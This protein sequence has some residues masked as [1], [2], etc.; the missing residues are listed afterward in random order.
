[1]TSIV[2]EEARK[3]I[4]KRKN[5]Y[6]RFLVATLL[7]IA[8]TFLLLLLSKTARAQVT[9]K[10]ADSEDG[11]N[12][13]K[14]LKEE[15]IETETDE[16]NP[17]VVIRS[18][19]VDSVGQLLAS[20]AR[21]Q[22]IAAANTSA[23]A[24]RTEAARTEAIRNHE[25]L[26]LA[27]AAINQTGDA[28]RKA[29]WLARVQ[30]EE[31]EP[32][33]DNNLIARSA[34]STEEEEDR[35]ERIAINHRATISPTDKEKPWLA[36][37]WEE[38]EEEEAADN[39]V[40]RSAA[41]TE[42]EEDR[43]ERIAINHRA[44]ISP[45]DKEKPWLAR[46]WEEEAEENDDRIAI[47]P[48]AANQTE[49]ETPWLARAEAEETESSVAADLLARSRD[50]ETIEE[51]DERRLVTALPQNA[52]NRRDAPKRSA[53]WVSIFHEALIPP[54]DQ[55]FTELAADPNVNLIVDPTADPNAVAVR[56]SIGGNTIY[57]VSDLPQTSITPTFLA[58]ETE[59]PAISA[60]ADDVEFLSPEANAFLNNPATSVVL[61]FP[62][63]AKIALLI[64]GRVVGSD[65]VGRTETDTQT[66]SRIQTWYGVTLAAGDNQ[67]EV[68]STDSGEVLKRL[69]V[70]VR[71]MPA[72]LVLLS[73]RAIPADGRSVSALR[74][75]L[76][77]ETGNISRWEST[78][79]LEA[80]DGQFLGADAN[81][82][83]P[84]FQ[85]VAEQ[86]EFIAELQSSLDSGLVQLRARSGEF[87]TFGQIQFVTPQRSNLISGVVDLRFGAQ[88]TDYY[89]SYREFLPIDGDD[90]YGIDLDAAVFATGNIGQ[91]LY[92]GAYNSDRTLN[93]D[94]NGDTRLFRANNR[95]G[96]NCESTYATYG[97]DS[98][99]DIVAPSLDSVFLRLERT[100]PSAEAATDYVM[101]GDYNTQEFSAASQL[102]TAT[103]RQLHGF[104][105][106][107]NF[108]NL[109]LTGLY[110]NNV[111]GFQRD[112]IAPDGTSGFYF[113]SQR[114]LVPGSERVFL[115]LEE[116]ERPGTVLERVALTRG[117]DY[118]IDYDR[119]TLL[120]NDP[121][122]R[123]QVDDFGLLLVRRIVTTY[124]HENGADTDIIGSRLQYNFSQQQ[125][126]ESWVGASYLDESLGS[127]GFSL[128][129]ADAQISI[130]D[131]TQVT[132]EI[133]RS[134]S[135]FDT[136]DSVSGNAYRVEVESGL[137][138]RISGRAYLRSTDTGFSNRATTS[139][140]PGQTRY[141]A[142]IA[143]QITDSTTLRA[144]F[145][146]E[147]NS[148]TAPLVLT[149]LSDL[150]ASFEPQP[151]RALDNSLTTYSLG[152][153][154][155][156]GES[157][158]EVDWLHRDRT[159]RLNPNSSISSDQLRTRLTTPITDR[160]SVVAQN[161]LNLSSNS[162]P[163]YPSR[164][165][166]GLN[167]E[168]MDGLNVGVNQ[169]F[170]GDRGSATTLDVS[171]EHTFA[172]D[173]TLHGRFST[174]GGRQ[175]GGTV[176]LEQGIN[177]APGLDLDLGFE[178]IFSTLGRDTAASTQF[179]QPFAPGQSASAL[180]LTGGENYSVGIS[181][182]DNPDFQASSRFEHR[183]AG[184]N[185]NTVFTASALGRITPALTLLSDYRT[186]RA[187]NQ[188]LTGLGRTSLFKLGLAYRN[189]KNDRFN[190]LLRYEHRM[191]PNS[192]PT[193][194]TLGASSETQEHLFSAE[195]IYAP[196][197]RWELYGKYALRNSRTEFNGAGNSFSNSN[198]SQLAQAR[199]TYRLGYRWDTVGELRWLGGG[200][201]S[202]TGFSV[203]A[204]YYPLPD[205]RISAGYSG[206][207]NDTDFGENRS[208]GGFY[209]G[210]TAKLSG[211]L[212][213]FATQPNDPRQQRE[214]EADIPIYEYSEESSPEVG[215]PE[216]GSP[217]VG[218]SEESS[219]EDRMLEEEL[220]EL[221]PP[222]LPD[223]GEEDF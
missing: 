80:S 77:D 29:P 176:G 27:R 146:R 133:A 178:K 150:L 192:V 123:T 206:G 198:T 39:L 212:D 7:W 112:T 203:E 100:S 6:M 120:F 126:R 102:F 19:P 18:R 76:V 22:N 98:H 183:R 204:G 66:R 91:W 154:Q 142:Q 168:V 197:W 11:E 17:N 103:N 4:N 119:G 201:Y 173:T 182:T 95:N 83:A 30:V 213:G 2:G 86:G 165:L 166:V 222:V 14:N 78:V 111:E 33:A 127:R 40:A 57:D 71:G 43:D 92:T 144:Q 75:Q 153:T 10:V 208:N 113:T 5:R 130:G 207:A 149:D 135:D 56:S 84:G 160:L 1:M 16:D 13:S 63:G 202:E 211:L 188:R 219:S 60:E 96:G 104:K 93:E 185:S 216:V 218:S 53:D 118:Q 69:M 24:A 163:I 59:E 8:P 88:G 48:A 25:R 156:F 220:E 125:G 115:E 31:E 3:L 94:C 128:F 172:S 20:A 108:G 42:E 114:D 186:A 141:G 138:D 41:S 214:S 97:D 139:F 187:A 55:P 155:Q 136:T 122:A 221:L 137:G 151:G 189:P 196:N 45:T 46:A 50:T 67:L 99:S 179:A 9:G 81:P 164:T 117:A 210:A 223:T 35:D 44:T 62:I 105:A 37:A 169:L 90:D 191:N 38:E 101:W 51:E 200:G 158:A 147:D 209:F 195:A 190:A 171:G 170:Y 107:Y 143:G 205:L 109:A 175:I 121:V 134:T 159:D 129:G 152:V 148:G 217:E 52:L 167:W 34:A 47:N 72:D 85:V 131:H 162:D 110:A 32:S 28:S 74:G 68:V 64:N 87:Q 21:S 54:E 12:E 180:G 58:G 82:D 181:Y 116:L 65:Y 161:E 70:T 73:P 89:D 106:N 184:G 157:T 23:E 199:A 193:N 49:K 61:K 174:I 124:Q 26:L 132:A 79:T 215:S 15:E 177:L 145:D 194:A 140:V 36:R